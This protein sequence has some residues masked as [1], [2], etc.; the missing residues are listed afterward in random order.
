MTPERW[1]FLES[2]SQEVFGSEDEHLAG[3]MEEA[4]AAGLPD[5]A[6]SADVG[7]LLQILTSMTEGTPRHRS[8]DPWRVLG[9]LD[10][11]RVEIRRAVDHHRDRRAPCPI[12]PRAVRPG[13]GR[14]SGRDQARRR[15]RG[16]RRPRRGAGAGER[17]CALPGCREARVLRL[18]P[19]R[20]AADRRRRARARRQR[21]RD[22][23]RV[24]ST[25]ATGPTPSTADRQPIPSFVR[26]AVPLRQGVL[27]ARRVS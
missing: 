12:R 3:L 24:G 27:I 22:R 13:R 17:R 5:I 4:T 8:G 9:D 21:L 19:H 14:G 11:S 26:S 7:R 18:L 2:Y 1:E 15:D 20:Q 10:R 16:A 25:R 6:V 23:E